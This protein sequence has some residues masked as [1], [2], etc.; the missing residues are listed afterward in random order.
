MKPA[1]HPPTLARYLE[2]LDTHRQLAR[3]DR[4]IS[5]EERA[6]IDAEMRKILNVLT[7]DEQVAAGEQDWRRN[8]VEFDVREASCMERG[9]PVRD[10]PPM[11]FDDI[12]QFPHAAYEIDVS[13]MELERHIARWS[14]AYNLNLPVGAEDRDGSTEDEGLRAEVPQAG[15]GHALQERP[16]AGRAHRRLA[17]DAPALERRTFACDGA[18]RYPSDPRRFHRCPT[19]R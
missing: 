16:R 12:P 3:Y 10:R 2:L 8:P 7:P 13:W 5:R 18:G 6:P 4:P 9:V 14:E 17:D 19:E 11:S 15:Q 1:Q